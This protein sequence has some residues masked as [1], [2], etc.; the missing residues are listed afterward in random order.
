[1]RVTKNKKGG[2]EADAILVHGPHGAWTVITGCGPGGMRVAI[3]AFRCVKQ[4]GGEDDSVDLAEVGLVLRPNLFLHSL[5]WGEKI[6]IELFLP[7]LAE[8]NVSMD[9][10]VACEPPFET[11]FWGVA[12]EL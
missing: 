10:I 6:F 2:H 1:M 12:E 4:W 5:S 8:D 11:L 3:P 9:K 7:F